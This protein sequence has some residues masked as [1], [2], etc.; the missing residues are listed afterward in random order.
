MFGIKQYVAYLYDFDRE[1]SN[2]FNTDFQ[3]KVNLT[4]TVSLIN[5]YTE[6]IIKTISLGRRCDLATLHYVINL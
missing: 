2:K 1:K 4:S 3:G 5:F 6:V